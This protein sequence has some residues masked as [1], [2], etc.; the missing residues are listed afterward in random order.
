[1]RL[2][3]IGKDGQL[4]TLGEVLDQFDHI[5]IVRTMGEI[6]IVARDIKGVEVALVGDNTRVIQIV[7]V[8]GEDD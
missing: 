2:Q 6:D 5:E 8:D 1:M 7:M 4:D 3:L